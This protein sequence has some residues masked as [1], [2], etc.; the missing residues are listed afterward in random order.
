MRLF[1][2]LPSRRFPALVVA[3][4]VGGWFG[5]LGRAGP[6][7]DGERNRTVLVVPTT[8]ERDW[9]DLAFL[10]AVPAAA[11]RGEGF[12]PLLT[13]DPV[14]PWRPELL[15][16]LR[17]YEPDSLIYL[18]GEMPSV[19]LEG[20]EAEE[21]VFISPD[22][23]AAQLAWRFWTKVSRGVVFEETDR[24]A[25]LAAS[26]LAARLGVPL[27]PASEGVLSDRARQV[28]QALGIR[29]LIYVVEDPRSTLRSVKGFSTSR[30]AG[31]E[32]VVRF[33][34]R[35]R[36]PVEYLAAC[37]PLDSTAGPA[38]KLSLAAV[39]FAAGRE[40]AVA[41]LAY[42]TKWKMPFVAAEAGEGEAPSGT[43]DLDDPAVTFSIAHVGRHWTT[44]IDLD[45][46]G[47]FGDEGDGP[48]RT[49]DVVE[50]AGRRWTVDLDATE[51]ERGTKLWLSTPDRDTVRGDLACY[52]EAADGSVTH[53]CL[54]GW[55]Q[56]LPAVIVSDAQGIDC[57][58]VSDLPLANT[59]D[60]PFV[61]LCSGRV[62]AED[63]HAAV[64][65]ANRSLLYEELLDESWSSS[66]ATAE[67][68]AHCNRALESVG[69]Q[70]AGHHDGEA[71]IGEDSPLSRASVIAHGS[72]AMWTAMG[73]TYAWDTAV[74]LAP[75]IVE[76][77][78]CSTASLDQDPEYRSVAARMLRNGAVA[79]IGNTR[80]GV[81]Q[82]EYFLT[83]VRNALLDGKT[84]GEAN[85]HALNSL[86]VAVLD[87]GE[88]ESGLHR[89]QLYS[90][91]VY[92]DPALKL[93][94]PA[95]STVEPARAERRGKRV[96]VHAPSTW[97][98]YHTPTNEEWKSGFE[99]LHYLRGAG[100]ATD[101]WWH[102]GEK[103]NEEAMWFTVEALAGRKHVLVE[104]IGEVPSP[105]G[106]TGKF[107]LD[108]H[109]D[110]TRSVWWRCRLIDFD[111]RTGVVGAEVESLSFR[112]R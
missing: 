41:T 60:D 75:C 43:I 56:V 21:I 84:L 44:R 102:G 111:M 40:G 91:A 13:V 85:R 67:W 37:N 31:A 107:F 58:L 14:G 42:D 1:R 45:G 110:G 26:A 38:H 89:Y 50:L 22:E 101:S 99:G 79:F 4:L 90:H 73:K 25:P 87:G 54:V 77:S 27:F 86:T 2:R 88:Q 109:P 7:E 82:Q 59:D 69:F 96:T 18:G 76:S 105:L 92:G 30:I 81:A 29:R 12:T 68:G 19:D 28:A 97:W 72:H 106:W 64:L 46:D 95:E 83:E 112:L 9:R 48:F 24:S 78:G 103:R 53:L 15:D 10:C 23:A 61:E 100:L 71:V 39:L 74:L 104:P 5:G 3:L 65:H 55:P 16:F 63:V 36:L 20:V 34:Q 35:E 47:A 62:I 49:G 8:T 66:F 108:E 80:R 17:R 93:H 70:H 94:L 98:C 11:A 6:G 52:L 32:G 51:G 57:D 33:L